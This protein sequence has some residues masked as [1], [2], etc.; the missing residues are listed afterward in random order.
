MPVIQLCAVPGI[1]RSL[2]A[3]C[4]VKSF[5]QEVVCKFD[6]IYIVSSHVYNMYKMYIIYVSIIFGLVQ[7][8]LFYCPVHYVIKSTDVVLMPRL[9]SAYYPA[10][11]FSIFAKCFLVP[12]CK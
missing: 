11:V 6:M 8:Q 1:N 7:I 5:T 12:I 4:L 9:V 10:I 3:R 2:P